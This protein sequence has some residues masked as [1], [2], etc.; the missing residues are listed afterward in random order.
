MQQIQSG[1]KILGAFGQNILNVGLP[2]PANA[3]ICRSGVRADEHLEVH[4]DAFLNV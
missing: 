4:H 1:Q 2:D 3:G